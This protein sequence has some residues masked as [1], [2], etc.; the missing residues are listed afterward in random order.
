MSLTVNIL[1]NAS[2]KLREL[3][4]EVKSDTLK[5]VAGGTGKNI[6]QEHFHQLDSSRPNALRGRRTHFWAQA[7][8]GT[9]YEINDTGAEIQVHHYGVAQR[10]FGGE[11]RPINAKTLTIP[12]IP[13]AYGKR[14]REFTNLELIWPR[15]HNI[16]M[17]VERQHDEIK[18]VKDR[19]KKH[20]GETIIKRERKLGGRVFFW[21]VAKADQQGD[22]TV[23]PSSETLSDAVQLSILKHLT[24]KFKSGGI[25]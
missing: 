3:M 7:A 5:H 15:G 2:P 11:I 9:A 6:F 14:A 21:L 23:L 4:A 20:K 18:I 1:D 25:S 24:A 22:P 12:A 16:G 13:E 8:R 17:L 19:R 10:F